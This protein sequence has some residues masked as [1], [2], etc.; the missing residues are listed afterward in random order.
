MTEYIDRQRAIKEVK[1]WATII[2]APKYLISEDT[3]CVLENLPAEDVKLIIRAKW[4]TL[5]PYRQIFCSHC[6]EASEYA[7]NYCPNCGAKM[8]IQNEM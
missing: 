3:I 1:E 8:E 2:T 4:E 7:F 5:Y 6:K